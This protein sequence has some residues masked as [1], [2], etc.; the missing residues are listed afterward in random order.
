[1]KQR[2]NEQIGVLFEQNQMLQFAKQDGLIFS[3]RM[4]LE[5]IRNGPSRFNRVFSPFVMKHQKE[6]G[7]VFKWL[8]SSSSLSSPLSSFSSSLWGWARGGESNG[9]VRA[10]WTGLLTIAKSE[11]TE[12]SFTIPLLHQV[13]N[14]KLSHPLLKRFNLGAF[15]SLGS[16]R[17]VS[18][19]MV[20][21]SSNLLHGLSV[22]STQF[23]F[24][25][26][27][28]IENIYAKN[29][30]VCCIHATA[31]FIFVMIWAFIFYFLCIGVAWHLNF[32]IESKDFEYLKKGL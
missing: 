15:F 27:K 24:T 21:M 3:D 20:K 8:H 13:L 30:Y 32:V 25:E 9:G 7:E 29:N 14:F 11:A 31:Y 23:L 16:N 1:V 4:E 28:T 5:K 17:R 10:G 6:V 12:A 19:L 26:N 22:Y 2:R 18:G